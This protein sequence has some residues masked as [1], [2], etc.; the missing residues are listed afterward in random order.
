M[1]SSD[2]I[3]ENAP[4]LRTSVRRDSVCDIVADKLAGMVAAGTLQVGDVLPSERELA[5]ALRVSRQSVRG[6][7]GKLVELGVL[8]VSQ[9]ARTRVLSTDSLPEPGQA[10]RAREVDRYELREIH[11]ARLSVERALVGDGAER[12]DEETLAALRASLEAQRETLE[13]PVRFIILDREFH[14]M[15]YVAGGNAALADFVTD[16]YTYMMDHRRR[17]IAEPDAI[18]KSLRDHEAIVAAFA[19]HDRG[20]AM[21]AIRR[22][23]ER[24]HATT[25]T[26]LEAGGAA[27]STAAPNRPD[28]PDGT[29]V[30]SRIPEGDTSN[31]KRASAVRTNGCDHHHDTR[32]R[33][34]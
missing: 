2:F 19:R 20:A 4:Q 25:R 13:D 29:P 27:S 16:L 14:R 31:A 3:L 17:A 34:P 21:R 15:L 9:G 10:G 7:I 18:A 30:T 6:G 12:V 32:E 33:T 24:I 22:H 28:A 11:A 26:L 8:A 5:A 1:P 23:I